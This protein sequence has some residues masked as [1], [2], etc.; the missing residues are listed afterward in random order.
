MQLEKLGKILIH[1]TQM[2]HKFDFDPKKMVPM[3]IRDAAI[4]SNF[5]F[6]W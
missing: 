3:A 5:I 1:V 2:L 4:S 6:K